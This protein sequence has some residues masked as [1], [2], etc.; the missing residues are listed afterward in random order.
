MNTT[1][2]AIAGK[3]WQGRPGGSLDQLHGPIQPI[4]RRSSRRNDLLPGLLSDSITEPDARAASIL[5]DELYAGFFQN[6]FD[7]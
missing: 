1:M 4:C 3:A 2:P 6:S 5:V 7:V